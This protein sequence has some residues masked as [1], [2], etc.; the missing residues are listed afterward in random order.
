MSHVRY[1]SLAQEAEEVLGEASNLALHA[2][3]EL[4]EI[5][6]RIRI[7]LTRINQAVAKLGQSALS[8]E[9]GSINGFISEAE[10]IGEK[11]MVVERK[12]ALMQ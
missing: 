12:I 4:E 9:D 11:A 10:R 2:N 1:R 5:R 8:L 6:E 7:G 3:E